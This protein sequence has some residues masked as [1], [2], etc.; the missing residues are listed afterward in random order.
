MGKLR[1]CVSINM[2]IIA[3]YVFL[4]PTFAVWN[5]LVG[6]VFRCMSLYGEK[7][8]K[9]HKNMPERELCV[10]VSKELNI[11]TLPI[12]YVAYIVVL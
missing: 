6:W 1:D 12:V 4:R 2:F 11:F 7:G 5:Y 9:S 8:F 3:Y 10:P